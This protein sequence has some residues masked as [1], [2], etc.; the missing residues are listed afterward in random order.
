MM[1][2]QRRR[3]YKGSVWWEA[4]AWVLLAQPNKFAAKWHQ[5][6]PVRN[7]PTAS[8]GSLMKEHMRRDRNYQDEAHA[9][10]P[11][12]ATGK[13]KSSTSRQQKC[14]AWMLKQKDR[15][16]SQECLDKAG[17]IQSTPA[18][19]SNGCPSAANSVCFQANAQVVL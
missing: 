18:H 4:L 6:K 15:A 17:R 7:S 19:R 5:Q 3:G 11:P 14:T 9:S 8:T 10:S 2:T 16:G 12:G 1:K 13:H